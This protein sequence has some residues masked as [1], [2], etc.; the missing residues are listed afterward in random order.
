M[1]R[2]AISIRRPGS[3]SPPAVAGRLAVW[4]LPEWAGGH[5]GARHL[6][7]AISVGRN[8]ARGLNAPGRR[9]RARGRAAV[10]GWSLLPHDRAAGR[11]ADFPRQDSRVRV[12][13]PR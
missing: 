5:Y 4:S 2:K 8:L 12:I 13:P 7:E 11:D 1:G 6:A 9:S 3:K 10:W